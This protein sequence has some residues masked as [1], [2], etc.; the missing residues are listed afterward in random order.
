MMRQNVTRQEHVPEATH[1]WEDRKQRDGI[2]EAARARY[3]P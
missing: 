3:I 2:Q 1:L